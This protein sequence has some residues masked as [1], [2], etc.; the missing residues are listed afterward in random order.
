LPL[1]APRIAVAAPAPMAPPPAIASAAMGIPRA[2]PAPS[3]V[4][5]VGTRVEPSTSPPASFGPSGLHLPDPV[6]DLR[7]APA[8]P[9]PTAA[10]PSSSKATGSGGSKAA[11]PSS[12]K[13]SR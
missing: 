1:D 13:R 3:F 5:G 12:S 10:A 4:P 11:A 8:D 7:N 2:F 9:P 6:A